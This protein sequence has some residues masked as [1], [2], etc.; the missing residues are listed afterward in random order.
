MNHPHVQLCMP[1]GALGPIVKPMGWR[2]LNDSKRF[3]RDWGRFIHPLKM[4]RRMLMTLRRQFIVEPEKERAR[5]WWFSLSK[6]E[7]SYWIGRRED[8]EFPNIVRAAG[9]FGPKYQRGNFAMFPAG[10]A[11]TTSEAVPTLNLSS[12]NND[13][14]NVEFNPSSALYA[15]FQTARDGDLQRD[16]TGSV[17]SGRSLSNINTGS[18]W[19]KPATATIGDDY[20]AKWNLL[21]G[22]NFINDENYTEDVWTTLSSDLRVGQSRS[23]AASINNIEIDIGDD[24]T[25]TSDVNQDYQVEAGDLV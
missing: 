12:S 7:R 5:A 20:E 19:I 9:F 22:T 8:G 10:T 17:G 2:R 14:N 25:S 16:Q 13:A 24:G 18:D 15:T 3:L 4:R 23:V 21:S 6:R 11:G 1:D